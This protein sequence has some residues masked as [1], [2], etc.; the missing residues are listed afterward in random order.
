[1]DLPIAMSGKHSLEEKSRAQESTTPKKQ[2]RERL[3]SGYKRAFP[4]FCGLPSDL[5]VDAKTTVHCCLAATF[6]W[7]PFL[8]S[9]IIN[10]P[11]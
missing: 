9:E 5:Q 1:M 3:E 6:N 7:I 2:T 8:I 4:P 10:D 11:T